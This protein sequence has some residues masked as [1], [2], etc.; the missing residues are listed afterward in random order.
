MSENKKDLRILFPMWMGGN[1]P[2]YV[3]GSQ[4]NNFLAPPQKNAKVI[5]IPV[6]PTN[7][8]KKVE[9]GVM[10]RTEVVKSLKTAFEAISVNEP[11]RIVNLGGDCLSEL[12]AFSYLSQKYG[13]KLGILWIDAHPDVMTPK[14]FENSH[15]HALALLMGD[16]D[17]ELG[18]DVKFPV[19]YNRVLIAG[20]PEVTDYEKEYI[21][22]H[23][24]CTAS[25]QEMRKD[26]SKLQHWI[27]KEKIEYLAVHLDLDVLNWESFR[28]T[29]FAS[30]HHMGE[31]HGLIMGEMEFDEVISYMDEA[32]KLAEIVGFGVC[33]HLP[34]DSENLQ[35]AFKRFPI[36][37]E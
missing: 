27:E 7:I 10:N 1:N 5:E 4:L 8:E 35:N 9:E 23:N 11:D 13:E 37:N 32:G 36:L 33:E 34:W 16:G 18:Q 17:K 3:L 28:S 19:P 31:S 21:K 29:Y 25:P 12:P 22:K 20:N 24:I 6:A 15:A 14:E 26:F 30:P 2:L